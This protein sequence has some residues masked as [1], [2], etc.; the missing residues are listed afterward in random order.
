MRPLHND[1]FRVL[2]DEPENTILQ[3]EEET[4][5]NETDNEPVSTRDYEADEEESEDYGEESGGWQERFSEEDFNNN[6]IDLTTGVQEW[7]DGSIYKGE[8]GFDLKLGYGEFVWN[9]GERYVGQFYKDH[10]HGKGVYFWPDGSKFTGSF[11]LSHKEGY[12]TMEFKDGR[13]YQGLYKADERFGP[14]IESHP[15]DSQDVGLWHRNHLIK[16]C[17]EIPK[18]FSLLEFP[19]LN[20]YFEAEDNKQYISEEN[21]T[22]W[23]LNEEKDPFFYCYKSLLLNDDTYTLPEKMYIYS[24]DTDHLPLTRTFQKEFDSHYFKRNKRLPYEKLWPVTNITP[25]MVKM[26]KHVYK[27]RH[28]Q[29]DIDWDINFILEGHRI[30]FGL[31]GP[32]ELASEQLIEKSAEG[33]YHRVYT[34]LKDSLAHP[35]IADV[36]GYTALAAAAM[37][38]HDDIINLLLDN[39]ADV[40]KCSDEGLSALSM[41]I[42]RYFPAESFQPNIAERSISRR[43]EPEETGSGTLSEASQLTVDAAEHRESLISAPAST[44]GVAVS[45]D[46]TNS[47]TET[48]AKSSEDRGSR[49]GEKR[50]ACSTETHYG[51]YNFKMT[52]SREMLQHG[53]AVL[54]QHMLDIPYTP[55]VEEIHNEGP[56]RRMA[57]SITENKKRLAT[58]KLLLKRGADP[59]IS[60]NPMHVLFFAVK[61]ADVKVVKLL[62]EAGARTD[63]KLPARLG[64]VAPLHI[65]AALTGE[66]GVK[67]TELL[68]HSVTDP[69]VRAED[70]DDTYRQDKAGLSKAEP[71][72]ALSM[73]KLYNETGPPKGFYTECTITP[74]EGGRTP[75]HIACE[76]EDS[77][78]NA[79]DVV[80]L[81]LNHNANPNVLWSGHSPL[82]LAI[83]NGNDLAVAELLA[84]GTDPNLPLGQ[85]VGNALC[86]VV[87]PVY[88]QNRILANKISLIN[89]LIAGGADMLMPITIGDD[90]KTAVGTVV[91]Y[92]YFKFYQDKRL[93]RTPF[94][95]LSPTERETYNNR[96]KLLEYLSDRL[97]E[98][99]IAREKQWDREELRRLKLSAKKK[100]AGSAGV[101]HETDAVCPFFKY[102]SQCGRS[103][104]VNLTPCTRCYENFACSK[105]CKVKAWNER[106]KRECL[107]SVRR[108]V[109]SKV[110]AAPIEK[111]KQGKEGKDGVAKAGRAKPEKEKVKK[112]PKD[113][114]MI[115][116]SGEISNQADLPYTGNYSYI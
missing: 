7:P 32:K 73:M 22:V 88:D 92:A 15:D 90:T 89:M 30:G 41:C 115:K 72:E 116:V 106:H 56:L 3:R 79:S 62:L 81:L 50:T 19:E 64:G 105:S 52:V 46:K 21:S 111:R 102:C 25:L 44:G 37:N 94:H 77:H 100:S 61:S 12:G 20:V 36:H 1:D 78:K 48:V 57:I 69:D 71:L 101:I 84:A 67:I 24:I 53:A 93:T 83:A 95:A 54:S 104:G 108:K 63:I 86:A 13:I 2:K 103:V 9:S 107:L 43:E 114:K 55:D 4:E 74:E 18:H 28:C 76:R 33:D 65:A 42:I 70:A 66:E 10:R 68:L 91:D 75:L 31:K 80:H 59:N 6:R 112:K 96:R 26:Q 14:G 58:I 11:Y 113:D 82:S 110:K 49:A 29:A 23:N 99:V 38:Y 40:N 98:C 45:A 35:D 16:L 47:G 97:R 39:G 87:N 109:R 85:A 34:I 27:Y 8:F 51:V 17:T 60:C 5:E